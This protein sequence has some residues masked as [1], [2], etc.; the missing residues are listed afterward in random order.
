MPRV[1]WIPTAE[2]M[3]EDGLVMVGI[4]VLQD[5]QMVRMA[6][7]FGLSRKSDLEAY[8]DLDADVREMLYKASRQIQTRYKVVLTVF[9]DSSIAEQLSVLERHSMDIEVCVPQFLRES[10]PHGGATYVS[11]SLNIRSL[12]R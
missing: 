12:G 1:T 2:N 9:G 4:H 7:Q 8:Q 5:P 6:E 11:G 10:S 3:L